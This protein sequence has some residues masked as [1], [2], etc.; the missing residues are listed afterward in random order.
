MLPTQD[1]L[2]DSTILVVDDEPANVRLLEAMLAA[3][4]YTNV[5]TETDPRQVRG[6]H[7]Q[8]RYDA[9]LLDLYMPYLNGFE[10]MEQL[11]RTEKDGYVPVLVLT[12]DISPQTRLDALRGG[13]RDFLTKPFDRTEVLTRLGNLLEVRLLYNKVRS[14]NA[15][16][17]ERVRERTQELHETRLQ[18]I[19]GLGKAAEYRDTDTGMHVVRISRYAALLAG[20]MGLDDDACERVLHA[21]PM[22][23]IGKIGIPDD[24][25]LKTGPL[26]TREWEIMKTHTVLGEQILSEYDSELFRCAA[27]LARSHHERWDGS[28]YPDGLKGEA[29]PLISRLVSVCDV[30]DSL[31]SERPY[32]RPWSVEDAVDYVEQRAAGR[33]DPE[34]VRLFRQHLSEILAIRDESMVPPPSREPRGSA[35]SPSEV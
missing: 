15:L 4:G 9:L 23:D 35:R 25:L 26:D 18:A 1:E 29:I 14:Q 31:V 3:A 7:L 22:H 33:F 5:D 17:E 8:Q 20:A 24:I 11:R 12:A 21:A 32:K 10:V 13:A 27:A 6:R 16:L 28:G 34:I 30:F 2:H 19:R